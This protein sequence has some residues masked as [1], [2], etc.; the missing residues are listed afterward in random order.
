[1]L[2]VVAYVVGSY[3]AATSILWTVGAILG[4][5]QGDTISEREYELEETNKQLR[6]R[7]DQLEIESYKRW[8]DDIREIDRLDAEINSHLRRDSEWN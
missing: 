4:L 6:E 5:I 7:V 2:E 8:H 1:M 3:M